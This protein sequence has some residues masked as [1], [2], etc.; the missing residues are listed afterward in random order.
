MTP[1]VCSLQLCSRFAELQISLYKEV[2]YYGMQ[3]CRAAPCYYGCRLLSPLCSCLFSK[4]VEDLGPV[5]HLAL[6]LLSGRVHLLPPVVSQAPRPQPCSSILR[7]HRPPSSCAS[8]A[9]PVSLSFPPA[10][11]NMGILLRKLFLPSSW[12]SHTYF[13]IVIL[14]PK[15]KP[16]FHISQGKLEENKEGKLDEK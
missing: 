11:R 16:S 5:D 10:S 12:V 7:P 15:L 1:G 9:F 8:I 13:S 4:E 2:C 3:V 6:L 14:A